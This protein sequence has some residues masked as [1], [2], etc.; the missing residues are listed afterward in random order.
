MKIKY[1]FSNKISAAL[2]VAALTQ[3]SQHLQSAGK[4]PGQRK[5]FKQ[6]KAEFNAAAKLAK[7]L[8]DEI[9]LAVEEAEHQP[10]SAVLHVIPNAK[11]VSTD[12]PECKA[13]GST[14]CVCPTERTE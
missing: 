10:S 3:F 14:S 2:A 8:A 9:M 11:V 7:D 4:M 1:E 12:A 13:C 6:G 5:K